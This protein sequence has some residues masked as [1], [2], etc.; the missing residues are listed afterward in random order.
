M[1]LV[2]QT[3]GDCNYQ[4]KRLIQHLL[5]PTWNTVPQY[6]AH[7][8]R[9]TSICWKGCKNVQPIYAWVIGKTPTSIS[10]EYSNGKLLSY[11]E[12]TSVFFRCFV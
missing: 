9:K 4:T 11:I 7:I 12:P 6:G 5:G 1:G 3:L 10:E 8:R 2:R